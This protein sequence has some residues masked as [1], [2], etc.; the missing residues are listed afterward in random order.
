[1][2]STYTTQAK[3]LGLIK[4]LQYPLDIGAAGNN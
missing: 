3:D 4:T 2:D 1:M